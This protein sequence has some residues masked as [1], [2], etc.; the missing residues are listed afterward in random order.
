MRYYKVKLR[1]YQIFVLFSYK[2]EEP[3]GLLSMGSDN[4]MEILA[5]FQEAWAVTS[6]CL[7]DSAE[8]LAAGQSCGVHSEDRDWLVTVP[9]AT[10]EGAVPLL[11]NPVKTPGCCPGAEL[12]G[13]FLRDGH[14]LFS[15]L[16]SCPMADLTSCLILT[17]LTHHCVDICSSFYFPSPSMQKITVI[18]PGLG[19]D[20]GQMSKVTDNKTT[21]PEPSPLNGSSD[22]ATF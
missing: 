3:W 17:F 15:A 4:G 1:I 22:L 14:S 5:D 10:V 12:P 16:L 8:P 6:P 11:A 18:I 21:A 19:E 9:D 20:R 13:H 2:K 7:R